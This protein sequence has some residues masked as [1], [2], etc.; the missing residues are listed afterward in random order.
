MCVDK[1]EKDK[2]PG[3]IMYRLKGFYCLDGCKSDLKRVHAY[4]QALTP[5]GRETD[6]Q[7]ATER[8][9]REC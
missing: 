6:R 2:L 9:E 3:E 5:P 1:A 8:V 4:R 7:G